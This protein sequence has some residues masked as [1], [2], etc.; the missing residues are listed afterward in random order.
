MKKSIPLLSV[1]AFG[2]LTLVSCQKNDPDLIYDA[3]E[4]DNVIQQSLSGTEYSSDELRNVVSTVALGGSFLG[5][6]ANTAEVSE[7]RAR[8][9]I[10]GGNGAIY[11]LNVHIADF[12]DQPTDLNKFTTIASSSYTEYTEERALATQEM[13]NLTGH[14]ALAISGYEISQLTPASSSLTDVVSNQ[15][16]AYDLSSLEYLGNTGGWIFTNASKDVV[17]IYLT[18]INR[19]GIVVELEGSDNVDLAVQKAV[20]LVTHFDQWID[21]SKE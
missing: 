13:T 10:V 12:I 3:S 5:S 2:F 16:F 19:F 11:I 4:S 20:A 7:A 18:S 1:F 8:Y 15:A 17:K 21:A 6:G 9:R 14:G